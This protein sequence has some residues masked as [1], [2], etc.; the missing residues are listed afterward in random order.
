M[1]HAR[2]VVDPDDPRAPSQEVWDRLTEDER[3]QVLASLPSK[4]AAEEEARRAQAEAR[5]ADEEA[6]RA[7][8]EARRADALAERI[9]RLTARLRELGVDPDEIE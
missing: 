5:R 4:R 8:E 1:R 9:E 2:Y 3:A 6:R 7:E